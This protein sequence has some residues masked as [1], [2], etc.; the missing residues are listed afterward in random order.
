MAVRSRIA[1]PTPLTNRLVCSPPCTAPGQYEDEHKS[2]WAIDAK[3]NRTNDCD[4]I[5]NAAQK[6]WKP[7][8]PSKIP[9][10]RREDMKHWETS[11]S[12]GDHSPSISP[13]FLLCSGN[14]DPFNSFPVEDCPQ[15]SELLYHCKQSMYLLLIFISA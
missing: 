7:Q 13:S 11:N 2:T 10:N 4:Q 14:S 12:G 9:P 15:G 3:S 1:H 8:L 5:I 6:M